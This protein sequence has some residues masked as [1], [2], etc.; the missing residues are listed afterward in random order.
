LLVHGEENGAV[1]I[2]AVSDLLVDSC[3]TDPN[4]N[5]LWPNNVTANLVARRDIT[6]GMYL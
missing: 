3:L 4:V 1:A 5:I 6:A 2:C